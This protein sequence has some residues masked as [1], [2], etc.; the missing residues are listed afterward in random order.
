MNKILENNINTFSQLFELSNC[1]E[2]SKFL[3]TGATGLIGATLT[4]CLLALNK[5]IEVT[6]PV[7]NKRK[8]ELI[9]E[10]NK[11]LHVIESNLLNYCL[12]IDD[13][14]DYVVHCAS[15]TDGKYISEHPVETYELAIQTTRALLQYARRKEIKGMVYVSSLEYYGQ[16]NDDRLITE[17]VQGYLDTVSSRS[18][19]PMGK[20]AAEYLCTIY[21]KQYAIPVKLK[22]SVLGLPLMII[23]YLHNLLGVL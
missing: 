23:A 22:L 17:D 16:I 10:K 14:F 13:Y 1:F 18:S 2:G 3:I 4:R 6:I 20:R 9:F 12:K 5:K 21:S 7:R 15:P 11:H 8:A 19:Y